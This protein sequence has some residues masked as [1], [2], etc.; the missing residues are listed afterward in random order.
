MVTELADAKREREAQ[1]AEIVALRAERDELIARVSE[2]IAARRA[3]VEA[4]DEVRRLHRQRDIQ[5]A[6]AVA[7]D[8][9]QPLN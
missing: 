5:R 2:M 3:V 4:E 7:R 8:P 1:L 9:G 6:L